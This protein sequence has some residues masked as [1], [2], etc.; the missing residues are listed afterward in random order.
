V[1]EKGGFFF[2]YGRGIIVLAAVATTHTR[3]LVVFFVNLNVMGVSLYLLG[4]IAL[5]SSDLFLETLLGP[6][7]LCKHASTRVNDGPSNSPNSSMS[8]I[9]QVT[10]L[11]H[12]F[13][14]P[15]SS[16]L[17]SCM[18]VFFP[19]LPH[20]PRINSDILTTLPHSPPLRIP[21]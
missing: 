3:S 16:S 21:I 8:S 11:A 6:R 2:W 15:P 18:K 13:A 5:L 10:A 20:L 9:S 17:I 12:W 4:M 14:C 1:G 19:R 7:S